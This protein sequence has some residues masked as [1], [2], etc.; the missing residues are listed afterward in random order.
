LR[1]NGDHD[2]SEGSTGIL[3]LFIGPQGLRQHLQGLR[4]G[5]DVEETTCLGPSGSTVSG[6]WG[7]A[8]G[9]EIGANKGFFPSQVETIIDGWLNMMQGLGLEHI[10]ALDIVRELGGSN[11]L[12]DGIAEQ[13]QE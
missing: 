11:M 10:L 3:P 8:Y 12:R 6:A 13:L 9:C 5:D 1:T 4:F 2:V 7:N